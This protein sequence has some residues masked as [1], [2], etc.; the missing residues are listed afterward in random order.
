MIE[1]KKPVI[2]N[3]PC[4]PARG[5]C[6]ELVSAEGR[7]SLWLRRALARDYYSRRR[8]SGIFS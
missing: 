5:A 6:P 3:R 4:P 8:I 7:I 2:T 1:K